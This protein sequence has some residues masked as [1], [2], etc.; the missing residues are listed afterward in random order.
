V[1]RGLGPDILRERVSADHL[2]GTNV[3]A[4]KLTGLCLV[5]FL[6][7]PSPGSKSIAIVS[8][9]EARASESL[10]LQCRKAVFRKYGHRTRPGVLTLRKEFVVQ[11]VDRCVANGGRVD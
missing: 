10:A 8:Q 9:A 2:G 7:L 3:M 11:A 1:T 5:L 6:F 4:V